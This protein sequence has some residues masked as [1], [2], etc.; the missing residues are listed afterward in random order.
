MI[1]RQLAKMPRASEPQKLQM[2][3][4]LLLGSP[5]FQMR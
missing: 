1:A 4:A 5:E 3:T 2:M